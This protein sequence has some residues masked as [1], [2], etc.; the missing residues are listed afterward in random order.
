MAAEHKHPNYMAIFYLLAVL[1]VGEIAVVFL[2]H[3]V[4]ISKLAVGVFLCAFA[5]VKAALVAMYFMHLKFE[6]RTLGLI[7]V[8]PLA[9]ATLLVFVI[10]PDASFVHH[11]TADV[12]PAAEEP[13]KH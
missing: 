6:T 9:I 7:A 5:I 4:G 3:Y 1:T 12:K 8:T 10:L 11:K 13:A 2:P